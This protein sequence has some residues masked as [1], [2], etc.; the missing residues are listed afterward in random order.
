MPSKTAKLNY[1]VKPDSCSKPD[2][3]VTAALQPGT[4]DHGLY[5]VIKHQ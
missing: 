1:L 3:V 2:R 4:M 5:P